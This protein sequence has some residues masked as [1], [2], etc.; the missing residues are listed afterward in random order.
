DSEAIE[1]ATTAFRDLGNLRFLHHDA[2]NPLPSELTP[3]GGF[4]VAQARFGLSHFADGVLG[5]RHIHA[6]L[7][8]GGVISLIDS[9]IDTFSFD[10]PSMHAITEVLMRS[11][12]MF[13]TSAAG[14]RH[15]ELVE[16]AGFTVIDSAV[17]EHPV[18]GHGSPDFGS[19]KLMIETLRSM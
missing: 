12:N 10:H 16:R 17:E 7:R 8:P 6:A 14:D 1:T 11:W 19:F 4:D 3:A 13:G 15:V 9:R 18:G 2:M 5:L